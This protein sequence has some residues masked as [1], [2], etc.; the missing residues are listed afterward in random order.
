MKLI[1]ILNEKRGIPENNKV[2]ISILKEYIFKDWQVYNQK[3]IPSFK[4]LR[5]NV[6]KESYSNISARNNVSNVVDFA[7]KKY[8]SEKTDRKYMWNEVFS[9]GNRINLTSQLVEFFEKYNLN[10]DLH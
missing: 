6:L 7:A 2:D 8:V 10:E 9:K 1:D 3:L 5:S 4:H